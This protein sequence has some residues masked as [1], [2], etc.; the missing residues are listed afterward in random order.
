[1]ISIDSVQSHR[2][3]TERREGGAPVTMLE[4]MTG[5]MARMF[6]VL[7]TTTHTAYSSMFL[8]DMEGVVKALKLTGKGGLLEE[9]GMFWIWS[10]TP[11][12]WMLKQKM[13][14]LVNSILVSIFFNCICYSYPC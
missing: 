6:G 12:L 5:N 3:W 2:A 8:V 9:W 10:E 11:L 1:M 7:D 13:L 4:D 14:T